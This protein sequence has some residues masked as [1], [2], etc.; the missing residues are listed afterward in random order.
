MSLILNSAYLLKVKA[1]AY[2]TYLESIGKK[3]NKPVS[4]NKNRKKKHFFIS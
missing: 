3:I 1:H 4:K 2:V